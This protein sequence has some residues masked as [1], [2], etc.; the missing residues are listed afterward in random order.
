MKELLEK[1]RE[2]GE[3]KAI[4]NMAFKLGDTYLEKGKYDQALPLL[5][6]AHSLSIK[7]DSPSAQAIVAL[8]LASL[9]LAR[10]E[11]ENA[12]KTAKPAYS[13]YKELDDPQ[14]QVKG[15]L[16]LG[17]IKW[18]QGNHEE[19]LTFYEEA[20]EICKAGGDIL[21]T[22]T[23]LDR[24]AKMYRFLE[25]DQEALPLFEESLQCWQELE[26]PDREAMTLAN[27]GDIYK[28][29]GNFPQAITC[30]EKAL[31]IY[32]GLKQIKAATTLEK[33][34]ELLKSLVDGKEDS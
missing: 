1:A 13:Y 18:A 21:G 8:A 15:C 31:T 14:G 17:D 9:Y 26:V 30:H 24:Q 12:E 27:L 23:F 3:E 20:K 4:A 32:K 34:L 29:L 11:A 16:L 10:E 6:E 28:Q 7:N 22:A 33:E 25:K 19:A 5:E 2:M